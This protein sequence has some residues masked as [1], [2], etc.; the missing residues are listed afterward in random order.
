MSR[1]EIQARAQAARRELRGF[2]AE[3]AVSLAR[4]RIERRLTPDLHARLIDES[5]T[6]LGKRH[7]ESHS[8]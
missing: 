3:L 6:T 5:I 4:T 7:E 8:G 1:E 2:A